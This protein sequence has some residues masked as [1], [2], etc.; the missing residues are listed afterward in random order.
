M[1]SKTLLSMETLYH[2]TFV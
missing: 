2:W 1:N